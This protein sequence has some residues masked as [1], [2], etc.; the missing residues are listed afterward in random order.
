MLS[1]RSTLGHQ[2]FLFVLNSPVSLLTRRFY[3]M[4][5]NKYDSYYVVAGAVPD[6]ASDADLHS[7]HGVYWLATSAR[8]SFQHYVYRAP[9][10]TCFLF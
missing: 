2:N 9:L 8:S 5:F 7:S 3:P 10:M 4:E 6:N 1:T